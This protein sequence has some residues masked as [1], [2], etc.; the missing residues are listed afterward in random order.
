MRIDITQK[1]YSIELEAIVDNI[2]N[3]RFQILRPDDVFLNERIDKMEN[4]RGWTRMEQV[5]SVLPEPHFKYNAIL[6]PLP[7]SAVLYKNVSQKMQNIGGV[8][9]LSI[10]E[11]RNPSLEE[12]YEGMKKLIKKQCTGANP[13]EQELFHGTS[14]EG[15]DGIKE[16]GFDDRY[17]NTSGLYGKYR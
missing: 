2:K 8:Q 12:T 4:I 15:I 11:I 6:V 17:F 10:E 7:R 1:P 5:L 16:N 13:T 9:I 3:K 14:G